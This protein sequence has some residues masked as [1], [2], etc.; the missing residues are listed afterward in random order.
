MTIS[1]TR[2]SYLTL[3]CNIHLTIVCLLGGDNAP[4][5]QNWRGATE[6]HKTR[7][8]F[9]KF[10]C[11]LRYEWYWL[12]ALKFLITIKTVQFKNSSR[13]FRH[14]QC[15]GTANLVTPWYCKLKITLK[16]ML[17][18][19]LYPMHS[20]ALALKNTYR[21]SSWAASVMQPRLTLLSP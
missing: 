19:L 2:I 7:I 8:S 20:T 1:I 21:I 9:W 18:A 12:V 16:L 15:S 6:R 17:E 3:G 5:L 10:T 14:F 4:R 11:T 13:H